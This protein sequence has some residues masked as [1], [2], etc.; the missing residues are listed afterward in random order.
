MFFMSH[1][2]EGNVVGA[3]DHTHLASKI[4]WLFTAPPERQ[5]VG[6]EE[7]KL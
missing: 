6:L 1:L 7:F 2:L 3:N 5:K 4:V